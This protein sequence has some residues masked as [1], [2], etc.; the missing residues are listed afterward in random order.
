MIYPYDLDDV[1]SFMRIA[2]AGGMSRASNMFN[3]PKATLSHHLR[4]LEDALNVELFTR[5]AKGLELTDAGREFFAHCGKIFES[6]ENAAN[7][8]QRAHSTVGGKVRIASSAEFGTS[9]I[10]AAAYYIA[11]LNPQLDFD[12]QVYSPDRLASGQLDFDCMIYVGEAPPSSLIRRKMGEIFYGLYANPAFIREFGMPRT[13]EDIAKLNGVIYLR[14]GIPEDWQLS[15]GSENIN[16]KCHPRFTVN[17]YWMAKYFAVQGAAIG[18]LPDFFVHYEVEQGA[19]VPVLPEW[20][21]QESAIYTLYP[22]HRYRNPRVMN[23]V[24]Q[25]RTEFQSFIRYPGYSLI[26]QIEPKAKQAKQRRP[27][28]KSRKKAIESA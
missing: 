7:A 23:L 5:K 4:R 26:N 2:Q 11:T 10:G 3:V 18:Y 1:N 9:I 6:C 14:N 27:N 19:L 22:A 17:E 15:K 24:K 13:A 8:A 12:T 25:M 20:R 16:V 28:G 21:S